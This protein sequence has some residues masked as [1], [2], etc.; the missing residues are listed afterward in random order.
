MVAD[1]K[2]LRSLRALRHDPPGYAKQGARRTMFQSSLNQCEQFLDA[3]SRSGVATKPV[4]L[5][6]GLSQAGRAIVAEPRVGNQA[7]QVSGHGLTA[8]TSASGAADAT[9]TAAKNG[10]FP[11]LCSPRRR[12]TGINP[13]TTAAA[14]PTT[15]AADPITVQ[16][17]SSTL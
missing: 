7:W 8:G 16:A 13:N 11:V 5:F 9:V 10:L 14:A 1:G 12:S 4:Q 3:A 17:N 15:P 6:Y 2:V